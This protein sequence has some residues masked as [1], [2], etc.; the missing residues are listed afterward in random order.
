MFMVCNSNIDPNNIGF[1]EY[2]IQ[3][4]LKPIFLDLMTSKFL[5]FFSM[6]VL[7]YLCSLESLLVHLQPWLMKYFD[8]DDVC[9]FLYAP[10]FW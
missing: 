5:M 9:Y 2:D 10:E 1:Y 3:T 7:K 8:N 4:N 6:Q